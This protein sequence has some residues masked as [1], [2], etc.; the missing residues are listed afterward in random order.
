[1]FYVLA[2]EDDI[3]PAL[4]KACEFDSDSDA[5]HLACAAKFAH[6]H[7]FEETKQFI[8]FTESCQKE[9]GSPLLLAL[10]NM[11]LEGPTI[12]DHCEGTIPAALS[13]AQLLKFNSIKHRRKQ[14]TNESISVRHSTTQETP[15]PTY[16]GLML[17][18]HTRKKELVDRLYHLGLSISYNRVFCLSAQMGNKSL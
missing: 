2:F 12:T 18:G 5:I 13:I 16:V 15:V 17:Q 10:V 9:S 3:G 14:S 7:M 1:M 8:G 4:A 6:D 11:I